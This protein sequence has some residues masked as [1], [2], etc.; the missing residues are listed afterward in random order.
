MRGAADLARSGQVPGGTRANLD[1]LGDRVR[2]APEI[3][4]W[5]RLLLSDAQTSGGLLAA[6]PGQRAGTA[7]EALR[8][9]GVDAAIVGA[10]TPGAPGIEVDP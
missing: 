6:V 2:F 10:A 8:A 9:A 1:W 3:P 5:R 7:L 4:V